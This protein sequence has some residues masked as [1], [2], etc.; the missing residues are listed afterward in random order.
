MARSVVVLEAPSNLGLK[1]PR[2]GHA[3]GVWRMPD[4]LRAAGLLQK[5]EA[6]EGGR[7]T[8]PP[9]VPDVDPATGIRNARAVRAYSEQ[10]ADHV[11]AHL[12][13]AE[14]LLVL[15]GDC[16]ILVGTMLGLRRLGNF[17]LLYIDGHTD[18]SLPSTTPSGGAAGMDLALVCGSGPEELTNIEGLKPLVRDAAVAAL[19]Y[20]DIRDPATYY[21][22]AIFDSAVRRYDLAATRQLGPAR[23]VADA[24][25]AV[26]RAGVEGLWIHVDV[27]VLDSTI[28]PAVD[29]PQLDGLSYNELIEILR[30]VL[31]SGLGV[32]MQVTIF[33]PE[34]DPDGRLA[35]ELTDVLVAVLK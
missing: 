12:P 7:V 27:D 26:Q 31:A 29:S 22:R 6:S 30:T 5:L 35:R 16:S 32:G 18:F 10:L 3:P 33:D 8:P 20:R 1:P 34:L 2:P 19:G 13:S 15:G 9:Y 23:S 14:F 28:F 21:G 11:Q 24:L 17:G 4:A 25:A